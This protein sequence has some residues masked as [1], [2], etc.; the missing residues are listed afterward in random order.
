ML[1]SRHEPSK[2]PPTDSTTSVTEPSSPPQPAAQAAGRRV[3]ANVVALGGSNLWRIGVSFALQLLIARLL[4]IQALAA[5][6]V[7]LAYLNVSQVLSELGL[8][9]LLV[10]D[11][12]PAPQ[13]RRAYFWAALG[14]Q[15]AASLLVWAG[16]A[17][18]AYAL[19]YAATTRTAIWLIGASLPFYAV[20]SACQTLFRAAER[21]ELLMAV[22]TAI[23]LLILA[24]SVA[25]LLSG[26]TVAHLVAILVITQAVSALVCA[27][28]V[29]RTGLLAA[30]QEPV[31]IRLTELGRDAAPFLG[32]SIADVLLQ[33]VD[34]LLLSVVG[35]ETITGL[36]S[37]AYNLVRVLVKL[38]QSFWQAAY[39][40]LSRLRRQ[41][42]SRYALLSAL[43]LR[44][45]LL[46]LLPAAALC[47]GVAGEVMGWLYATDYAAAAPALQRLVWVAPLFFVEM[48]TVTLLMI[49]ERPQRGLA[50]MALNLG[51]LVLLLPPFTHR[52]GAGGAA[53]A[54]LLA[55]GVAALAGLAVLRRQ[56]IRAPFTK[57]GLAAIAAAIAGLLATLLPAAWALR[58][59][60]GA[61]AY[62]SLAWATGAIAPADVRLFRQTLRGNAH[63]VWPER[64][65][66][67]Q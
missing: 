56:S 3:L 62:L 51:A 32:L 30:P 19:P 61:A 58:L 49:E 16:L 66:P 42:S 57:I 7:A 60:A 38:V 41:A 26:A 8:P 2:Q 39:P 25:A 6:T 11:L 52:G 64:A 48:Y 4:G 22:E 34:I 40:T 13:H 29:M 33:R 23:N 50:V 15:L 44:Y 59:A 65:R 12:A 31:A 54:A 45:G 55:V 37:A 18:L 47:T 43:S 63:A 21:M 9:A 36:Y 24:L 20:T 53:W 10:R 14:L 27:A 28:V 35:G 67:L 5:Y 46:L 1:Q 17:A